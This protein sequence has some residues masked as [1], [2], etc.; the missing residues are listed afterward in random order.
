MKTTR[1][2]A[3]LRLFILALLL[4]NLF[5]CANRYKLNKLPELIEFVQIESGRSTPLYLD[6]IFTA[7]KYKPTFRPNADVQLVY[8]SDSNVI[9]LTPTEGFAG[10]TF[11]DFTNQDVSFCL[12]VIVKQKNLVTFVYKPMKKPN[13]VFVM[14]NFN[15]WNRHAQP[16]SDED[17][18]GIFSCDVL[19]DDGVYEYQFVIDKAEIFDPENPEKTDNGFGYFNSVLRV[20]APLADYAANLYILPGLNTDTLNLAVDCLGEIN[21]VRCFVMYDN[22]L[23]PPEIA[24]LEGKQLRI[25]LDKLNPQNG[26]H[27]LRA[28]AQYRNQPGNVVTIYLKNGQPLGNNVFIW[29]DACLYALMTDRFKN[30]DKTNDRPVADQRLAAQTNF[31]GGDFYGIQR[32]IEAGYFDSL[33]INT[34]WISPVNQTTNRAY[35]EWPEPHNYFSGYH[36][37]WPTDAKRTDPRFGSLDELQELV[38]VAHRHHI[39]ILLDYVSN[40]VHAEHPY[41]QEHRNW[42]GQL[43]LPDGTQNIRRWDEY[44]L[45]TWFDTFLPS[46]DY[47]GSH[48]ALQTMTDNAVWWLKKTGID[49]FR[50]DATKHVPYAFWETLTQK[51]KNRV[52]PRRALNVFQIGECFGSNDLIK[53]Y[54][55]NGMLDSQFN[56]NQFFAARRT[57]VDPQG[58]FRDL[59]L[60]IKKALEVYGYNHLMGNLMDSHDQVRI[61]AFLDGDLTLSDDGAARAWKQPPVTVDN[62]VTYQKELVMLTYILTIPGIPV[63][64]YGDEFGLTGANDP[65]NRRMMRFG[66]EL[67]SIERA[68]LSKVTRLIQVRNAHPAL[69]RGDYASLKAEKDVFVYSRGDV[70]E[71]LII[72]LNKGAAAQSVP[73]FLPDWLRGSDV[74][75]L[76]NGNKQPIEENLLKLNLPAYGVDI[77]KV[78]SNGLIPEPGSSEEALE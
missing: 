30:G 68:Q 55:N 41:F 63:I 72:A 1:I 35:Q 76:L 28:T 67:S 61:M 13:E 8:Q 44:R 42:F 57:F 39:K 40:H 19:L 77:L 70:N 33:G 45:T 20:R 4:P 26:M 65:D 27:V 48:Q 21:D 38:E 66:D 3:I 22:C 16:M 60:S 29:N 6:N 14:G 9:I 75:S 12:P 73:L 11:I 24:R 74:L 5:N 53:S 37:Y 32:A 78:E 47:E 56:F 69:R 62:P 64:D 36:G 18:D 54:V 2:A 34:I 52:N 71:R 58:D 17:G 23:C 59:D 31:Q 25:N 43:D 7:E 46:F 51:V 49:G 50:H 10:L 15:D